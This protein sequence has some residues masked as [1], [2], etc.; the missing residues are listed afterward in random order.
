LLPTASIGRVFILFP[1]PWPKK[2]HH[3]RR[4]VSPAT[5]A[6]IARIVRP[7]GELR[8]ATDVGAYAAAILQVAMGDRELL[9]TAQGPQEWRSRGPDWPQTRYEAKAAAAGRRCY[10]FRFQRL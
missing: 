6:E 4:I 2:R 7:G 10:F 1:D 3:K 9:W 8:I 5:L